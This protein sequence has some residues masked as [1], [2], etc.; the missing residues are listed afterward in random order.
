MILEV[1]NY[2]AKPNRGEEFLRDYAVGYEERKAI[3]PLG[4]AFRCEI[5]RL[6][7]LTF[8]WPYENAA[9]R[10]RLRAESTKLKSWPPNPDPIERMRTEIFTPLPFCKEFPTGKLG[11]V[12]ELR[13]YQLRV[14]GIAP[15][16]ETWSEAIDARRQLSP[17]VVAMHCEMGDLNKLVHIWAYESLAH[18]A[19]ARA[20]A[21][22]RK[23]WP[24]RPAPAGTILQMENCILMPLSF[25]PLQ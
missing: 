22:S 10:D 9:E 15:I 23:L 7:D 6:S 19:E 13:S 16:I 20:E 11:P 17:L 3:S 1:R 8:I 14:G 18:R 24:P 5:G 12:F 25:S 21:A 4:A 2:R